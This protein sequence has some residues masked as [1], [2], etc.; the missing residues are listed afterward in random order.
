MDLFA[1]LSIV[2]V[3]TAVIAGIARALKQPLTIAYIL[4]GFLLTPFVFNT[5]S[6][7]DSLGIFSQM[8]IAILLFIVG[9][10]LSPHQVKDFGKASFLIGLFQV[11]LTSTLGFY[12]ALLLGFPTTESIYIGVALA[13]SSTII[14]LK[15]ISDKKDLEKLYGRIAIGI[16]LLQDLVAMIA[17]IFSSAL[18]AQS[19]TASTFVILLLKGAVLIATVYLIGNY[20]LPKLGSF[21]AR[22]QEYLLLFS[23]AWG[24]GLA[25]VFRH[26]GFSI[27]IG[28]LIAGVALS[29]SPY[30]HEISAR[31]RPLRDF[32]VVLFFVSLGTQITS[33]NLGQL[34]L[35]IL[36][37]TLFVLFIKAFI[38][39]ALVGQFRYN[40]KTAFLEGL[41]LAQISEFSLILML[42][43]VQ[44]GH[45]SDN[46]LTVI[47]MTAV[48]TI[49]ISSYL[50]L[51]AEKI[52]PYFS[53]FMRI[54]ERKRVIKERSI[55]SDYEV[56]LFGCNRLGYDFIRL[57]RDRGAGFLAV[58][59]DPALISSLEKEGINCVYGDAE[60]AE[61]LEDI[62]ITTAKIVVSTIPDYEA[63][64]FLVQKIRE[65]NQDSAVVLLSHSIEEALE[66]YELG[67]SYVI[68]PH[69]LSG[70]FA[71]DMTFKAGYDQKAITKRKK[72]HLEY[73]KHRKSRGQTHDVG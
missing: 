32:F 21:F 3:V 65:V 37:L 57:F 26:F 10:H 24:F 23:I 60:D 67:A 54:F 45:I 38:V 6:A 31:L 68:L 12:V 64:I 17:L 69:F 9:L 42:V 47:V 62:N 36:V 22:S 53:K 15:L 49:A 46:T 19:P 51:Y 16:L 35:Q 73:L 4:S 30:S 2:I 11:L 25:A 52:Y 40:K 34:W 13:F 41:S 7:H 59:F 56:V 63:N 44:A 66:L 29:V 61:F 27:E 20:V 33:N 72:E 39:A 5:S 43:G 48:I 1:Q 28:A 18:S 55:V 14:V 50:I 58:D 8:G 71:A 70:E